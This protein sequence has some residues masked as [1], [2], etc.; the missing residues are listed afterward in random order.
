MILAPH[1]DARFLNE[2]LARSRSGAHIFLSE[3][4]PKLKLNGPVLKIAQIIKT[5]MAS[6]GNGSTI[7][8]GKKDDTTAPYTHRNGMATTS[9]TNSNRKFNSGGIHKQDHLQ[10]SHQI[11]RYE[12]VI[13]SRF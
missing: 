9:D 10:Q 5:V 6:G 13:Y 7:Y 12:T 1:A 2:S 3:N 8:H 11:I 4:E